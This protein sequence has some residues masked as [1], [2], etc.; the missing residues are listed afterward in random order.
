MT[1]MGANDQKVL[2]GYWSGLLRIHEAYDRAEA[3]LS[4]TVGRALCVPNCGRCCV[5]PFAFGLE[6]E[7]IASDLLGRPPV[8]KAVLERC[9]GWIAAPG[10]YTYDRGMSPDRIASLRGEL[11]RVMREPC[12]LLSEDK[13]CLIYEHRPLTC[14][15]YGVTRLAL[16]ECPR[17]LGIGESA[18]R[19]AIYDAEG[20]INPLRRLVS[21]TL[22]SVAERRYTRQAFLPALLLE[23]FSASR[24]A[25][26][27][28]AGKVPALKLLEYGGGATSLL[29]HSEWDRAWRH[30]ADRAISEQVPLVDTGRGL[31]MEVG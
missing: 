28:D 26:L 4:A 10:A 18:G 25:G 14:R 17:P 23:R 11:S 19:R 12:P 1:A 16:P 20:G 21:S 9:E 30:A 3:E 6:G 5:S 13:R 8:L 29:W 7:L 27:V 2:I 22:R 15:A 31:A 24:L